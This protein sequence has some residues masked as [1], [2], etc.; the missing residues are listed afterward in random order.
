[1]INFNLFFSNKFTVF[2]LT[3]DITMLE[4][5]ANVMNMVDLELYDFNLYLCGF[6][7]VEGCLDLPLSC[8]EF[9]KKYIY[10]R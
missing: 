6:G 2:S 9:G 3:E 10:S 8:F 5:K 4:L 1:M 7:F